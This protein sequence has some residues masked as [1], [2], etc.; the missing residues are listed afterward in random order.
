MLLYPSYRIERDSSYWSSRPTPTPIQC[1][2]SLPLHASS[3]P[4]MLFFLIL[5][6]AIC[7]WLFQMITLFKLLSAH[8]PH[9]LS[10][11]DTPTN[12]LFLY[13]TLLYS[14]CPHT[15]LLSLSPYPLDVHHGNGTEETI[16]WLSPGLET[17]EVVTPMGFG[18][19]SAPRYKP[20]HD[21][22]DAGQWRG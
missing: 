19:L 5:S 10:T 7:S 11:L 6:W 20:W 22:N 3:T 2:P 15:P 21:V 4:I 18:T 17:S 16:R 1:Y 8:T 9:S 13:S 14:T 12:P